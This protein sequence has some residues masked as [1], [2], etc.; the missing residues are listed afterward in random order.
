MLQAGSSK[1]PLA[2]L[3]D[4]GVDLAKPEAVVAATRLMERTIQEMQAIFD[5]RGAQK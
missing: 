5:R 1:P 3:R 2:I 4:A